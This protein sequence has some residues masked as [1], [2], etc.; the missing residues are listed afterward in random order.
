[1]KE[2]KVNVNPLIKKLELVSKKGISGYMSGE[3]R[4]VFKGRGLEFHGYRN[5][6]PAED[7]AKFID[8]KASLRSRYLVIKELVEERNNNIMFMID[9]SSSMSFGSVDKLKNEYVIEMFA[10]MAHSLLSG[11]D[12]VGLT[13]FT[14]HLIKTIPANIGN[15]QYY[16]MLDTITNPAL[17]EGPCD[18]EKALHEFNTIMTRQ[19]ILVLIS[20][21]QNLKG[22]WYEKLKLVSVKHEVI[23][24]VVKDIRDMILPEETGQIFVQDP[25]TGESLLIDT[26][27]IKED[28]ERLVHDQNKLLE[29]QLK[30]LNIDYMFITTN[31]P[32]MKQLFTFFKKRAMG[33]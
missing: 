3:F 2:F 1:M 21:F 19:A 8:W 10:S 26:K 6:N 33:G 4:S 14:D 23:V 18:M 11:G 20:D 31:Q 25:L 9:A 12:S 15:K 5:Y 22:D 30:D 28:F 17:Y 16:M 24:F 27:D 32:F 29:K 13:L 7:D